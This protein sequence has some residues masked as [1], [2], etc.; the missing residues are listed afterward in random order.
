M[1]DGERLVP[2]L[3]RRAPFDAELECGLSVRLRPIVPEDSRRIEAAYALLSEE[4][5]RNRF[6]V[7]PAALSESRKTSLST[8]DECDHVAW[9]VLDPFDDAFPGYAG[10]SFWRDPGDPSRAE[11]AFTVTDAWQNH[12]LATLL[13]SIL[14]HE[15]WQLGVRRF[16]GICR[17]GHAAMR[18]WWHGL[19]G[20]VVEAG[21]YC[22]LEFP[23]ENPAEFVGRVAFEMPPLR[24]RVDVAEWLARWMEMAGS[25]SSPR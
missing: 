1:D 7:T 10:A 6:W 4:S 20:Q 17:T 11:I 14:F 16:H 24:R 22:T 19:G 9:I 2:L 8:T 5:R 23:L 3:S 15:G 12:G 25:G 13:F 18:S 21:R